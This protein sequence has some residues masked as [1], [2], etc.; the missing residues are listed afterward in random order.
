[1]EH[2]ALRNELS[3]VAR[4]H[5]VYCLAGS[6]GCRANTKIAAEDSRALASLNVIRNLKADSCGSR[7]DS[8]RNAGRSHLDYTSRR[9]NPYLLGVKVYFRDSKTSFSK[10]GPQLLASSCPDCCVLILRHVV[11]ASDGG[12]LSRSVHA[13]KSRDCSRRSRLVP[14]DRVLSCTQAEAVCVT[15]LALYGRL[16]SSTFFCCSIFPLLSC[17]LSLANI[18]R[19]ASPSRTVTLPRVID[20]GDGRRSRQRVIVG[21]PQCRR[22]ASA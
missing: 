17:D 19:P 20:G 11:M 15:A 16:A 18:S 10:L 12:S 6:I 7:E 14:H 21:M 9:R 3:D 13:A 4:R 5:T 2:R 8:R 22:C 1:M